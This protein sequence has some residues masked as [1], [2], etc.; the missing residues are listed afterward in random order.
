MA[1]YPRS[2]GDR[3]THRS[4]PLHPD[5]TVTAACG[6]RFRPRELL[7][8]ATALR[9]EPPTPTRSVRRATAADVSSDAGGRHGCLCTF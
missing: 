6:I 1:W 8:G 4:E 2:I 7:R 5:G 3:D 9:G